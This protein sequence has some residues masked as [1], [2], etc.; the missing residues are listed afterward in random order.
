M[1]LL[2]VAGIHLF[3]RKGKICR[4]TIYGEWQLAMEYLCPFVK[5]VRQKANRTSCKGMTKLSDW[6]ASGGLLQYHALT[7]LLVSHLSRESLVLLLFLHLTS[8][9]SLSIVRSC[10][11][12][13][14]RD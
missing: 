1:S 7:D 11:S 6:G 3:E 12:R 13:Q 14:P 9:C 2:D 4:L 8:H 5:N 10:E